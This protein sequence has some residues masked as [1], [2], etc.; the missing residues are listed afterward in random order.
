MQPGTKKGKRITTMPSKLLLALLTIFVAFASPLAS[1][2]CA[3]EHAHD[4]ASG[5]D[6]DR[7][8][9]KDFDGPCQS[10]LSAACTGI[11]SSAPNFDHKITAT[12]NIWENAN[13]HLIHL[14]AR[15]IPLRSSRSSALPIDLARLANLFPLRI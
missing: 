4:V 5:P 2:E 15:G 7:Q 14:G 13:R 9:L 6:L 3:L 10:Y 12:Y 8:A 11:L 1:V